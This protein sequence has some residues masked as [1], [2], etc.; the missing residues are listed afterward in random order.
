M[1]THASHSWYEIVTELDGDENLEVH[2][3][4]AVPVQV[5]RGDKDAGGALSQAHEEGDEAGAHDQEYQEVLASYLAWKGC[6]QCKGNS[7]G[8]ACNEFSRL[9]AGELQANVT[10]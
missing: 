9:N 8:R 3:I 5:Q 10:T 6:E 4:V 2:E 7:I 1:R